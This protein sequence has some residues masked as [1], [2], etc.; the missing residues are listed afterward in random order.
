[1]G[2][3]LDEIRVRLEPSDRQQL[4]K[5]KEENDLPTDQE[6][7]LEALRNYRSI[8]QQPTI[9]DLVRIS[10][11]LESLPTPQIKALEVL[12]GA[13]LRGVRGGGRGGGSPGG[14]GGPSGSGGW[15][16]WKWRHRLRVVKSG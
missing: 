2:N 13:G 11:D 12:I 8:T 6:A 16:Q 5:I 14:G 10:P 4:E 7:M 3:E 15:V 1:M 9:A